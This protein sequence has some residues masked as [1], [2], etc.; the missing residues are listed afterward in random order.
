MLNL[1]SH[2]SSGQFTYKDRFVLMKKLPTS[3]DSLERSLLW[4]GDDFTRSRTQWKLQDK[5]QP[6]TAM[7]YPDSNPISG[8]GYSLVNY[9]NSSICFGSL[10]LHQT[11]LSYILHTTNF[12]FI[13]RRTC[14]I[15]ETTISHFL[16]W[17]NQHQSDNVDSFTVGMYYRPD[18]CN[19]LSRDHDSSVVSPYF[20]NTWIIPYL[21]TILRPT[22]DLGLLFHQA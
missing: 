3:L 6:L 5:I 13:G 14:D 21:L 15:R 18:C 9:A 12:Y 2:I 16:N 19:F 10:K 8:I 11:G 22:I 17:E 4:K 7:V 1:S 20:Y